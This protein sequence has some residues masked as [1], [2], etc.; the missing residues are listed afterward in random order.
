MTSH[1]VDDRYQ[2]ESKAKID[3][4][5]DIK[6]PS[7]AADLLMTFNDRDFRMICDF[8]LRGRPALRRALREKQCHDRWWLILVEMKRNVEGQLGAR[9]DDMQRILME[10]GNPELLD[11]EKSDGLTIEEAKERRTQRYA[12]EHAAFITWRAATKRFKNRTEERLNEIRR[13]KLAQPSEGGEMASVIFAN[14]TLI[15]AIRTHKERVLAEFDDGVS[16][17]DADLWKLV[18]ALAS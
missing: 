18:D 3:Q 1:S 13:L 4:I 16:D 15:N 12:R 17:A 10:I 2:E 8:E 9:A 7:K 5:E 14:R 11:T 6:S